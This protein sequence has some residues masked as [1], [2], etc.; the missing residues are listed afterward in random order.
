MN[1]ATLKGL[2]IPEGVV[3]QIA[4]ASGRVLWSGKK[5]VVV[6]DFGTFTPNATDVLGRPY[7]SIDLS[8]IP[9]DC[10]K[11]NVIMYDG[12]AYEVEYTAASA[13]YR[14]YDRPNDEAPEAVVMKVM[15]ASAAIYCTDSNVHTAQLGYFA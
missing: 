4:D 6:I 8:A 1:F 13:T 2:T 12:N 11:C 5:F 7:W 14:K 9:S 3:T 15:S 10:D